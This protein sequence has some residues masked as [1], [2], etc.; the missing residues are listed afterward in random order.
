M[1][2]DGN[3]CLDKKYITTTYTSMLTHLIIICLVSSQMQS[4]RIL[5]IVVIKK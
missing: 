4:K 5:Y 3:K 2:I 1:L